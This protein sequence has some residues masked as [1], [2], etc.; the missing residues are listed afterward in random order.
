[1]R[2][3]VGLENSGTGKQY[4]DFLALAFS[5]RSLNAFAV[6]IFCFFFLK[7]KGSWLKIF[8]ILLKVIVL[9][10]SSSSWASFL[11]PKLASALFG[12]AILV[13]FGGSFWAA[14][15]VAVVVAAI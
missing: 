6:S 9:L 2:A 13:F 5:L 7:I 4:G 8:L 14:V 3:L 12:R 1:M 10:F 15:V 11:F